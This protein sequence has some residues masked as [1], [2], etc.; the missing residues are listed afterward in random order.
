M[1]RRIVWIVAI[2]LAIGVAAWLATKPNEEALQRRQECTDWGIRDQT[3]L[4]RCLDSEQAKRA[5]IAPAVQRLTDNLS[6]K[7]ND[8]IARL[9]I[10]KTVAPI[11][12]Y[13]EGDFTRLD[14]TRFYASPSSKGHAPDTSRLP[15]EG[16]RF[17]L[18]GVI[19]TE[20]PD[21][22]DDHKYYELW[23]D[24]PK[25]QG[26]KLPVV[27]PLDIESLNRNERQFIKTFCDTDLWPSPTCRAVI[28]GH[29]GTIADQGIA[30]VIVRGLVADEVDFTPNGSRAR[31][32][33]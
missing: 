6:T 25:K 9:A 15:L 28:Y 2:G 20:A 5:A 27:V 10:G 11:S 12:D 30:D 7:Y 31:G 3:I 21:S 26:G 23:S 8:Q 14:K 22:A 18:A 32:S 29:I 17:R 4:Q 24:F 1:S 16:Q 33:R 19:V 13:P